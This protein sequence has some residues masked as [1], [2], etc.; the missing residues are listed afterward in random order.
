MKPGLATLPNVVV[1]PHI[2]S[3]SEVR[4]LSAEN[5]AAGHARPGWA[6]AWELL[7]LGSPGCSSSLGQ[8]WTRA[9]S[10]FCCLAHS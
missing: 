3:A 5:V 2:A 6:V 4:P 10:G 8:H 9:G 7:G 1:V